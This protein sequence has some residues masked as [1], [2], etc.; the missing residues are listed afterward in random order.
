MKLASQIAAARAIGDVD[1]AT[2]TP[3]GSARGA[4]AAGFLV[5]F[6][7]KLDGCFAIITAVEIG[8]SLRFDVHLTARCSKY[9]L[10]CTHASYSGGGELSERAES[11]RA[12]A[13]D[14]R[15]DAST[16][17]VVFGPSTPASWVS[18]SCSS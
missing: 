5:R 14:L 1:I 17:Q 16:G 9:S 11:A 15:W 18:H 12:I 10:T 13:N 3:R 2:A 7:K 4:G 6:G 8:R